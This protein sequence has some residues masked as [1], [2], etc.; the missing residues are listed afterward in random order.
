MQDCVNRY[1]KGGD[2]FD[3]CVAVVSL[4]ICIDR[5]GQGKV[6]HT[7]VPFLGNGDDF[8]ACVARAEARLKHPSAQSRG[9]DR[10]ADAGPADDADARDAG[11]VDDLV[12]RDE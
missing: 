5:Y 1:E 4:Q 2:P 10:R 3:T 9:P 6:V 11:P 7:L 8:D 12:D